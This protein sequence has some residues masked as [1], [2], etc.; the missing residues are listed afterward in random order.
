M[1][2]M[3]ERL[4][5]GALLAAAFLAAPAA[6]TTLTLHNLCPYPVWP[7]VTPN[8]GFPSICGNDIR[9]EGNGHGLV[10][11]P[12]P[13]TFWSGQLV[14]R[15]GCAPPPRCE[16][17]SKRPAG[18][19]QLTVHSA[20]GAPRPDLAVYSVSLVGGFNVPVV[21]SPQVIG[22]DGPCPAL[23]CAADLN[24]GCPPAQRVVGA[25][26]RVVACN[27]PPGYFKQRC[28]LTRTTPVDR[29]PVEQ[30]CYAPG[31]LKVVFC[32]PAMVDV[33]ADAAAQPDVVVAEN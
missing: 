32:Q 5:I 23:G 31:E 9:L 25:G 19:V 8:T 22:G 26:G 12:F 27:G 13:A 17:G 30:H 7:L 28:P 1:A 4:V 14:A 10:S 2:G 11:F 18:V 6:G 29:E 16:T 24:A 3:G 21:V 15:T 20:E 33:D